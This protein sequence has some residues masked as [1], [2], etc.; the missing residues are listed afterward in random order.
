MALI[1]G[2]GAQLTG[3]ALGQVLAVGLP[4]LPSPSQVGQ[5]IFTG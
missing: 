3:Q 2:L 1:L 5:T 4:P